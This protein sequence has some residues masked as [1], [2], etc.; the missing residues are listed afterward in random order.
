M[1]TLCRDKIIAD[2]SVRKTAVKV[3]FLEKN[4]SLIEMQYEET[5][6]KILPF[7]SWIR[8]CSKKANINQNL[9]KFLDVKEFKDK[10][11]FSTA[12]ITKD[13]GV[14]GC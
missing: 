1:K 4:I 14:W 2:D 12:G 3:N 11:P 13:Y 7:Q 10:C 6:V 9:S 8:Q 5:K